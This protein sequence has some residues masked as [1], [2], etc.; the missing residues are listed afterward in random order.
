[1]FT[2]LQFTRSIQNI[3]RPNQ[4][5]PGHIWTWLSHTFI[6]HGAFAIGLTSLKTRWGRDSS[7]STATEYTRTLSVPTKKNLQDWFQESLAAVILNLFANKFFFCEDV[8]LNICPSNLGSPR[9]VFCYSHTP[10]IFF[11]Q[12]QTLPV[13]CTHSSSQII[14]IS[15]QYLRPWIAK[16]RHQAYNILISRQ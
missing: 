5:R 6:G 15:S 2:K 16:C 11:S 3:L 13:I 7:F 4:C 8:I 1:L 14:L 9:M 12:C 10:C